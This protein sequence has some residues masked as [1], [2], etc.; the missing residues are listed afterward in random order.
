MR[1]LRFCI[2]GALQCCF[3]V[4]ETLH[5]EQVRSVRLKLSLYTQNHVYLLVE[6]FADV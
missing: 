1:S 4:K 3:L 5:A 2:P 6:F